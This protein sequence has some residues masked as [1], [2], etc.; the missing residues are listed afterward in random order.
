[1]NTCTHICT[2]VFT[3]VHYTAAH[4]IHKNTL[5]YHIILHHTTPYHTTLHYT[6]PYHIRPHHTRPHHTVVRTH[7]TFN[8]HKWQHYI[9]LPYS[10]YCSSRSFDSLGS[11]VLSESKNAFRVTPPCSSALQRKE[12]K[13]RR[14]N[15]S[16]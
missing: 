11:R 16:E 8:P 1:M 6:I 4:H 10:L 13:I 3:V 7:S 14:R 5:F 9:I 2:D 12:E 15:R